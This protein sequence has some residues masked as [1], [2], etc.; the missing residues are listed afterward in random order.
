MRYSM[1]C[2]ETGRDVRKTVAGF[3]CGS[4]CKSAERSAWV[5]VETDVSSAVLRSTGNIIPNFVEQAVRNE[6][7]CAMNPFETGKP[8]KKLVDQNACNFVWNKMMCATAVEPRRLV[9][10]CVVFGPRQSPW[11]E[12]LVIRGA[13]GIVS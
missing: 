6:L 10:L 1:N 9:N 3:I 8:I 7:A 5:Q 11:R 2:F 12:C 4:V 13:V